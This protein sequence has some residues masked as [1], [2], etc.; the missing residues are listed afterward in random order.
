MNLVQLKAVVAAYHQKQ[1]TDLQI[2]PVDLFLI[3]ANNARKRA[4]KLHDF[5]YCRL[6]ATLNI[7]SVTGGDLSTA[8]ITSPNASIF[9]GIRE[10]VAVQG[11]RN[12]T[13]YVPMDFGRLSTMI[14]RKR[15][16]YDTLSPYWTEWRYPS[17]AWMSNQP[18]SSAIVQRGT[19]LLIFP[20]QINAT[21]GPFTAYLEAYGWLNP[22]TDADLTV[23]PDVGLPKD[24]L[25]DI[26]S[27]YMQWATIIEMNK[28][29]STYVPRQEGNVGVPLE[30]MA[31]AWR[32]LMVWDSNMVEAHTAV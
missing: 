13:V 1:I 24:F 15:E 10:V 27:S 20:Q 18:G 6:S 16:V 7:D 30:E 14:E 23:D 32:E 22:Y 4:E 28:L 25:L 12:N 3:A 9:S 8:V 11:L 31:E 26:G 29:F 2:G 19:L 5:E 17:D 21:E